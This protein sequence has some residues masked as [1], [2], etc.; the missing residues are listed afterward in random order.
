M[1]NLFKLIS[2]GLLTV[3]L[4][5][6]GGGGGGTAAA[7]ATESSSSQLAASVKLTGYAGLSL[8]QTKV[9]NGTQTAALHKLID[10]VTD[11]VFL[12]LMRKQLFNVTTTCSSSQALQVTGPSKN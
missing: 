6:C 4:Y 9:S 11:A 7:P 3:L 10:W 8:A 2:I 1:F 12:K 5:G